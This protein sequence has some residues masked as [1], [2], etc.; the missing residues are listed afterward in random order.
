MEYHYNDLGNRSVYIERN[1]GTI[2]IDDNYISNEE[3]AFKQGSSDLDMYLPS[4]NPPIQR[5]EVDSILDWIKSDIDV[6][7][8]QRV[9]LLYGSAGIGKSVVMHDLLQKLKDEKEYLTL[10]I[11]S[12]QFEFIDTEDLAE[13]MHLAKPL[14]DVIQS[15]SLCK[16]RVVLLIDQIDA[17]SL[18]LSS[19]RTPLRSLL[20]LI[21]EIQNIENVR[22][23]ISC[24]PYDLDYDPILES[25]KVD[26][27]WELKEFRNEEVKYILEQYHYTTQFD[28]DVI[29]FLGN[30]LHL[31]LFLKV[32]NSD[33]LRFPLTEEDLYEELWRLNIIDTDK[34]K[35]KRE[36]LIKL[37]DAMVKY[38]HDQQELTVRLTLLETEFH[39]EIHHLLHNGILLKGNNNQIQFF[40]QT[41]F[42]YVYARRFVELDGD[43]LV[44]L[45][46][47]HQGLF[48]RSE[49]KSVLSFLRSSNPKLYKKVIKHILFDKDEN[50]KPIFRYH[51][52]LL[53]LSSMAYFEN[54][55]PEE[56][57]FL[58]WNLFTDEGQFVVF[59]DAIHNI[60]WFKELKS[61]VDFYGGW[62]SQNNRIQDRLIAVC[63]RVIYLD[64]G[65]VIDYL[66]SILSL[67]GLKEQMEVSSVLNLYE[68][69]GA[70][71]KLMEIYNKI[72]QFCNG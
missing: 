60:S 64:P 55:I 2:Y 47:H 53:V 67:G 27:K 41:M 9:G 65:Y 42:D 72:L 10:G 23:V 52:R 38:M 1:N 7:N 3:E 18:S 56:Q 19:N 43:L 59:M 31:H 35:C 12:D 71:N 57:E 58:K 5:V 26:Q 63:G 48:V 51:L 13:K 25:L 33:T 32:C 69:R 36:G 4:I 54:P 46:N 37:L 15:V 49:V 68:I 70:D 34:G 61:I 40:H 22:I 20:R 29:H 28:D 16:A 6:K 17:L 14:G 39:D 44:E 8:P 11:K 62:S 66:L 50:D 24:R 45:T 30:P 21:Q